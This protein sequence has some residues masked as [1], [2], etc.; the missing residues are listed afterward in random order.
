MEIYWEKN[1]QDAIRI[2]KENLPKNCGR[3][4]KGTREDL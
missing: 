3:A 4:I 1:V 2:I